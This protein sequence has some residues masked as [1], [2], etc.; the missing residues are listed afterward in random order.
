M[1]NSE[2]IRK[3]NL[4]QR[5][6][7]KLP[8]MSKGQKKLV[9]YITLHY[10]KAVFMTAAKLGNEVGVSESTVV[11]FA[12]LLGLPFPPARIEAYDISNVGDESIVA[13]M[14]VCKDGKMKRSDY[15][16]FKINTT[17]GRDDYGSRREALSRRLSH[18]GDSSPSLGER[19]DLILL[20]GGDT[21]VSTVKPILKSLELDIPLFGMVQDDYHKTRAITDGESEISIA[22]EVDVYAFVYNI[23]EEAHRFAYLSSQNSQLKTL[24]KSSLESISGI[25]KKK[26]KLLLSAMPLSDIKIASKEDLAKIQGISER[27][28]NNVYEYFRSIANG[29]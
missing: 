17:D 14:V 9:N 25:G 6:S 11:R 7:E 8:A 3:M 19:P 15:R 21:H 28:A 13:S 22:K 23:Q 10:S 24:T 18:I 29:K 4:T 1:K 5:M 2:D 26:A 12:T 27:D 16:T 20:D